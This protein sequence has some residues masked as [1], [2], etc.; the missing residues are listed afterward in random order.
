MITITGATGKTGSGVAS[1]LLEAGEKVRVIGRSAERLE[2]LREAGAEVAAGDQGDVEFLTKAF[3]GADAV[4]L[5]IPPKLDAEDIRAYYNRFG[6]VAATAIKRSGVRKVVFLS[7]LGAEKPSGTGPVTGLHDVELMLARLG[8]VDIVFLRPGYFMENTLG[9]IEMIHSK[10][11]NGGPAPAD[12]PVMLAAT[13][14]ISAKAAELLM[15]RTFRG[16][17]IVEIVGDRL[18]FAE[19]T[20][21][22]GKTL[23]IPLLPYIQFADSDAEAAFLAMGFSRSMAHSF[24]ELM[25]A[26]ADGLVSTTIIDRNTPNAPTRFERFAEEVFKPAFM[27]AVQHV[28]V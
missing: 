28:T 7:S 4:Y 19:M 12:S 11:I 5:L 16:H 9:S 2:H 20:A 27:A 8:G 24:V 17:S 14:D 23:G 3:I 1:M 25:H 10:A 26:I 15:G 18:S 22:L 6:E 13:A 21:I